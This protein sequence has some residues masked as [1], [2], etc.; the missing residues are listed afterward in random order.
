[1]STDKQIDTSGTYVLFDGVCNVCS[2]WVQ[3]IIKR[4]PQAI[5]RFA[6]LQSDEA[7]KL[8]EEYGQETTLDSIVLVDKG[9]VYT[10]ST[11]ILQILRRLP[12]T[13]R[14]SS[15]FLI[16]PKFIRDGFYRWFARNRYRWFGKQESCM[17]PTPEIRARFL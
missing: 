9:K 3:F 15:V 4:D 8:L 6:S 2:G 16:V 13:W 5:F 7:S 11:A 10:E 12:G 14:F 17:L 1:M